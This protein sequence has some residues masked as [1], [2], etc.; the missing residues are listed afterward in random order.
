[1]SE[2]ENSRALVLAV[3][4]VLIIDIYTMSTNYFQLG[5]GGKVLFCL[6]SV[7][8]IIL[9]FIGCVI[10]NKIRLAI[11]PDFVFESGFMGLLRE[12]LFWRFG[13]QLIGA[14]IGLTLGLMLVCMI[15]G[16]EA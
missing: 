7:I 16:I 15:L 1:M 12:R 2:S 11:H 14:F 8:A 5:G 3:V 13:P 4:L 9:S 6:L 10:G